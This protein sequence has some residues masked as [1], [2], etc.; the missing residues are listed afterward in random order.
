MTRLVSMRALDF[1]AD[2][3]IGLAYDGNNEVEHEKEADKVV[4]HTKDQQHLVM[5]PKCARNGAALRETSEQ[6]RP[7]RFKACQNFR[8]QRAFKIY[9]TSATAAHF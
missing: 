2:N 1:V 3:N 8:S 9:I 6:H 4:H 5:C 7:Q